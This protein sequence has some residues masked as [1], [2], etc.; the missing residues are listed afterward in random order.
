MILCKSLQVVR[1]CSHIRYLHMYTYVYRLKIQQMKYSYGLEERCVPVQ[2]LLLILYF[3]LF[4][5][6]RYC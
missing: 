5:F 6:D 3:I 1:K 4:Y 2:A